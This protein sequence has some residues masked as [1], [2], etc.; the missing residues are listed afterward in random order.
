MSATGRVPAKGKTPSNAVAK[1]PGAKPKRSKKTATA[2]TQEP[3][4]ERSRVPWD[5]L[6]TDRLVDWLEDNPEDRQKLFSDL[7]HDAKK[8]N[9]PHRVAKGSK[10]IFYVKMAEYIFSVDE[11]AKVHLEVKERH[12][13][14]CQGS[15]EPAHTVR[16]PF[17]E[18]P[19]R[20]DLLQFEA[21]IPGIR[22]GTWEDGRRAHGGQDSERWQA[23]QPSRYV[24]IFLSSCSSTNEM[25]PDKLLSGFPIWER[26]H[27]FWRTLPSFNP[28]AVSSEPGQDLEGEALA[29]LFGDQEK[30]IESGVDDAD[31]RD[32]LWETDPLNTMQFD[33][34]EELGVEKV[35]KLLLVN[36]TVYLTSHYSILHQTTPKSSPHNHAPVLLFPISPLPSTTSTHR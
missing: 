6:C 29:V 10:S 25:R 11:D 17:H 3:G 21:Q 1:P 4:V 5:D 20:T 26:L 19:A 12:Q 18:V 33:G 27:G 31:D 7:S 36:R 15:R 14:I 35:C 24:V 23:V 28:H 13:E 8:E 22:P 9:R 2:D 32:G 34:E 16:S 30:G